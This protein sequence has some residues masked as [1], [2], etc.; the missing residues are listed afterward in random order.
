M[1]KRHAYNSLTP[2]LK[3]SQPR[4]S[5]LAGYA[6][7]LTIRE[8]PAGTASPPTAFRSRALALAGNRMSRNRII[9]IV[10]LA[11]GI[12]LVIFGLNASQAPLD[13]VSQT[14]TGR[15]TQTTMMYLII[16][17]IAIVGGGLLAL[18]GR[19]T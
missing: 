3:K 13:Q 1:L 19:R 11:V 5:R 17:I 4:S 12:V 2:R 16:G 7:G 14:V 15:F 6:P 9:G 10:I 8:R 18:S